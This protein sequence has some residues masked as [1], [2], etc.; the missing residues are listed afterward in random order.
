[1]VC[2]VNNARPE[3]NP[4]PARRNR[5]LS[6]FIGLAIVILAVMG[7]GYWMVASQCPVTFP[8]VLIVLGVVPAIYLA[9]M[10][11]ALTGQE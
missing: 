9:L 11:L 5:L 7:A 2:F 10:Y 4:M 1:M 6:W 8:I 3:R